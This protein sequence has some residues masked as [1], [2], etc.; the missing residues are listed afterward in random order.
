[1][2]QYQPF[3][4]LIF[5]YLKTGISQRICIRSG[6]INKQHQLPRKS[7]DIYL[8]TQFPA[9]LAMS[10]ESNFMVNLPLETGKVHA[11]KVEKIAAKTHKI[12]DE[13]SSDT[14]A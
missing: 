8:T 6:I 7:I 5:Q 11:W 2:P 12:I 3:E 10:E 13:S 1:M 9:F 14:W 4:L